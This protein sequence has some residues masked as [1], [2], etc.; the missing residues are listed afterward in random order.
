MPPQKLTACDTAA[1]SMRDMS[2]K[3]LFGLSKFSATQA[4]LT[5]GAK[6]N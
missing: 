4:H 2:F 1:V 6:L 3:S 5:A